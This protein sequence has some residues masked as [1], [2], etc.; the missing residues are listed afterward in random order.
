MDRCPVFWA[1][2]NPRVPMEALPGAGVDPIHCRA[3]SSAPGGHGRPRWAHH[4]IALRFLS[5]LRVEPACLVHPGWCGCSAGAVQ[6]ACCGAC[7]RWPSK[8]CGDLVCQT[9][10]PYQRRILV[11]P[12][13]PPDSPPPPASLGSPPS[14][15]LRAQG[16]QAHC[17]PLRAR[18]AFRC[19]AA[20]PGFG[21]GWVSGTALPPV[22]GA[23][24]TVTNPP[25]GCLTGGNSD[26]THGGA[27]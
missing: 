21:G 6:P 9:N 23:S 3:C 17:L 19:P 2:S 22:A 8:L 15:P 26:S 12:R 13:G 20:A 7:L 14:A 5:S 10:L 27:R 24:L 1:H 11:Q 18:Y 4:T 25:K 16:L